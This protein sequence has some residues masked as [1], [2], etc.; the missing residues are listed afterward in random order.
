MG[1]IQ[2]A[3]RLADEEIFCPVAVGLERDPG[4]DLHHQRDGQKEEELQGEGGSGV[5]RRQNSSGIK[6]TIQV[7]FRA[8]CIHD[9]VTPTIPIR[10]V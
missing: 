9:T 8:V 4:R 6:L 10:A 5:R 2:I 7:V 1:R 3:T